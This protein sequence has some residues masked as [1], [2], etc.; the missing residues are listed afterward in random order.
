MVIRKSNG[1]GNC[2]SYLNG[3]CKTHKSFQDTGST[4]D[5]FAQPSPGRFRGNYLASRRCFTCGHYSDE[6]VPPSAS[7]PDAN[8]LCTYDDRKCW[9]HMVCDAWGPK[10]LMT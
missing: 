7:G 4:C 6:T 5:D 3:Y 2:G 9:K 8:H 1:C 10:A